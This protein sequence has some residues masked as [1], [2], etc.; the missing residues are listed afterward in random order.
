MQD[1]GSDGLSSAKRLVANPSYNTQNVPKW[2]CQ[3]A[4]LLCHPAPRQTISPL[5]TIFILLYTKDTKMFPPKYQRIT[6]IESQSQA[7]ESQP[8]VKA[9]DRELPSYPL[10]AGE[11]RP[12][13]KYTFEP[14]YPVP[15]KTEHVLGILGPTKEVCSC[16]PHS[17]HQ[18]P[19]LRRELI[20]G[21]RK[22]QP[23]SSESSLPSPPIQ[24]RGLSS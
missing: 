12:N 19:A 21:Y 15:G 17:S 10:N 16:L 14:R 3:R 9:R 8:L 20:Q 4:V 18:S 6:D 2:Q 13:V 23:S 7:E 5:V 11:T 1:L 24:R 22:R